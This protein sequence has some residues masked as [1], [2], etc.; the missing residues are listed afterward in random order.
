MHASFPWK[1][2][3]NGHSAN[4]AGGNR[5]AGQRAAGSLA[6]DGKMSV[7]TVTIITNNFSKTN[8]VCRFNLMNQEDNCEQRRLGLFESLLRQYIT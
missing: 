8:T 6:L 5:S 7:P 3:S 1:Q 4:N 2:R